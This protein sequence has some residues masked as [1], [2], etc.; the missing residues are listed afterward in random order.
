MVEEGKF[1][2]INSV[3]VILFL[4]QVTVMVKGA[5]KM[6]M[7]KSYLLFFWLHKS[8]ND[9]FQSIANISIK[10]EGSHHLSIV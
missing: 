8:F 7:V 3:G 2:E 6:F 9:I 4:R 1:I 10:S 5:G